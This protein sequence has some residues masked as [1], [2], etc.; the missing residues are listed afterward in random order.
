[1]V[2]GVIVP[3]DALPLTRTSKVDRRALP[4]PGTLPAAAGAFEPPATPV[5]ELLAGIWRDLLRVDRT[6]ANDDFF[7]LG[8]HS[9]LATRVVSRLRAEV[10]LEVPLRT[11]FER[12]RLRD[13]AEALEDLLLAEAGEEADPLA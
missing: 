9:L 6:G 2:P 12:P 4:D 1:M 3:L 10:G 7:A 13:L 11:L 5:E 8:G